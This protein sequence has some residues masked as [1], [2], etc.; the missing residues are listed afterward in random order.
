MIAAATIA[1]IV[2]ALMDWKPPLPAW[3]GDR[4]AAVL[5]LF[6]ASVF[7]ASTPLA[8]L[9]LGWGEQFSG[10]LG[11]LIR[12]W[13][14]DLGVAVSEYLIGALVIVVAWLWVL[15]MLPTS[16]L[17]GV[18]GDGRSKELDSWLIW[19]GAIVL[20][21]GVAG[22]PGGFGDVLRWIVTL[23]VSAGRTLGELAT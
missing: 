8:A 23:G 16:K 6:A 4:I 14:P 20:A 17:S 2:A 21:V 15:A 19:G 11:G 9:V 18:L 22:V 12:G 13:A 5:A 1:V 10:W 3:I 7:V